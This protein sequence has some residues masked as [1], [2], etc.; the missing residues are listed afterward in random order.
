[1]GNCSCV[2]FL[3]RDSY[4][5]SVMWLA[6]EKPH[7]KRACCRSMCAHPLALDGLR[8]WRLESLT[9]VRALR[10]KTIIFS[11]YLAPSGAKYCTRGLAASKNGEG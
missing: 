3:Y 6:S 7:C 10:A 8:Q 9:R 4:R 2:V 1:M 5:D 11:G